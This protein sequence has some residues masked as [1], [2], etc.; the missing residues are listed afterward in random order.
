[1]KIN[2]TDWNLVASMFA[3]L[4]EAEKKKDQKIKND[5]KRQSIPK[6]LPRS[7]YSYRKNSKH[8]TGRTTN[9][10]AGKKEWRPI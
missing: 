6:L 2:K 8:R 7:N 9:Q 10:K 5:A 4:T 3:I 1:M